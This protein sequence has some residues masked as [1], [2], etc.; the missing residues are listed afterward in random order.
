MSRNKNTIKVIC[1]NLTVF[2]VIIVLLETFAFTGRLL[3]GKD[4]LG[5]LYGTNNNI[6]NEQPCVRMKTHPVFSHVSDHRGECEI[7]GGYAKE[8][9][10]FYEI[11][12]NPAILT[13]GGSSS[14]GFTQHFAEG[15][16][17][18]YLLNQ[19]VRNKNFQ[20]V[21]G[22]LSGYS[23]SQELLKILLEVRAINIPVPIIISLNGNNDL[24]R[25][26]AD[27][28][29]IEDTVQDMYKNQ[30][31]INQSTLPKWLPNIWSFIRL[32]SK[33]ELVDSNFDKVTSTNDNDKLFKDL[34]PIEIWEKNII[35]MNA[36]SNSIG[37]KYF[38]F[39]QPLMGLE[40]VQ[41]I[42][43]D[44]EKSNDYFYLNRLLK[45]D[46]REGY[47]DWYVKL[48]RHNF[49]KMKEICSNLD[50]CFDITD[51]APP[52]GDNYNDPRHHNSKGNKIIAEHINQIIWENLP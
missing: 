42:L 16:T 18:P 47:G 31:W 46:P 34:T 3:L 11:S 15:D 45:G 48:V 2:F 21:N 20:V 51:I 10:V 5:W 41:S 26:N 37:S 38:V 44:D 13:L 9:F 32:I 43:P 24:I 39:L 23:S 14:S 52:V 12:D 17:W 4:S 8:T 27:N 7:K 28:P 19:I 40:G 33:K 22:G 35:S 29:F 1:L 49:T 30:L 36:I 25:P 6:L 50:F